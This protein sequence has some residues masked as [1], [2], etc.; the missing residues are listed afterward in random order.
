MILNYLIYYYYNFIFSFNLIIRN[1]FCCFVKYIK[2]ALEEIKKDNNYLNN[3]NNLNSTE[4]LKKLMEIKGI[5]IKVASCILLFGYSKFDTFPIDTWVKKYFNE[6]REEIIKKE[7]YE[8]YG[9][10][11]GLVIQYMFHYSRNRN[12]L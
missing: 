6:E 3:I 10:Y 11:S 12:V 5:G 8:R 7:A 4:A 2:N 9:E 1:N